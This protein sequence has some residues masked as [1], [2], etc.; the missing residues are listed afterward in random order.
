MM[1]T[2]CWK[3]MSKVGMRPPWFVAHRQAARIPCRNGTALARSAQTAPIRAARIVASSSGAR[4]CA[5]L[6]SEADTAATRPPRTPKKATRCA[7]GGA[8]PRPAPR[9]Q[10]RRAGV[11]DYRGTRIAIGDG[12]GQLRLA[13]ELRDAVQGAELIVIPL[14]A[15]THD[16][17]APGSR[18]CWRT[19]RWCS[20][21]PA[22]SAASC[23]RAP[24]ARPATA[25]RSPMPRP[26]PLPYLAR[27]HGQRVVI[28]GY[29]T[30]LPTGVLP[31]GWP[32][33]R[34]G[35]GPGLSQRGA[36]G[37]RP[38]RR[39]DECR[40]HHPPA[41]HPDECRSLAAFR[42]LGHPQ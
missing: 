14:P 1:L 11:T 35:A 16:E 21:R 12:P 3:A 23:S 40:P 6:S 38:V 37:R 27:K 32:M 5:S 19:G 34:C 33:P 15:T 17:L 39:A 7:G 25:R 22:P 29:A 9:W 31:F 13:R 18:R 26:A 10:G 36:G 41:A 30:R 8:T 4:S 24:S 20:C 42:A 2:T 28:S